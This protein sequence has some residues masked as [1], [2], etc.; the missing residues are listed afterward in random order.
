M[1]KVRRLNFNRDLK[2]TVVGTKN[3]RTKHRE[4]SLYEGQE[5]AVDNGSY[6]VETSSC[7]PKRNIQEIF[8]QVMSSSAKSNNDHRQQIRV[9]STKRQRKC[10]HD[11]DSSPP[12]SPTRKISS[13][14]I[15]DSVR[16]FVQKKRRQS[17]SDYYSRQQHLHQHHEE[18][19]LS[20]ELSKSL[21]MF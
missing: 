7:I 6:F 20:R 10:S 19:A 13:H 21:A 12:P 15:Y 1:N 16:N 18:K 3:D 11:F 14:K 9:T 4:V 17:T 2:I 8:I 5:F